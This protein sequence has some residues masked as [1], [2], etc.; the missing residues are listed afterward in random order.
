MR[1]ALVGKSGNRKTKIEAGLQIGGNP[2]GGVLRCEGIETIAWNSWDK[3]D[4]PYIIVA[5]IVTFVLLVVAAI[6]CYYFFKA[7]PDNVGDE[8]YDPL[9]PDRP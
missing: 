8:A 2:R 4:L 5:G 9:T 1:Q 3:Q 6:C 7:K